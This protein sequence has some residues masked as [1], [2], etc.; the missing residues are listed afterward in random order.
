MKKRLLFSVLFAVGMAGCVVLVT[1][2]YFVGW[3]IFL[4]YVLLLV[5]SF[6]FL[7]IRNAFV[8]FVM[9]VS[10]LLTVYFGWKYTLY[11]LL[12][13]AT[14]GILTTLLLSFGWIYPHKS[15]SR[16]TYIKEISDS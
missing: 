6:S 13:G 3:Q 12:P 11:G 15:F 2:G 9:V 4:G 1:E 14:M 8:I 5:I 16:R 10:G 7:H